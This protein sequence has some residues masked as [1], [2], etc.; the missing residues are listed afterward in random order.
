MT[1]DQAARGSRVAPEIPRTNG[2]IPPGRSRSRDPLIIF[3]IYMVLLI[4]SPSIYIVQPL[5]AAGTPAAIFGFVI[6]LLWVIG[7]LTGKRGWI[8]M[9]PLHWF[10]GVFILSVLLAFCA[11]ML[12]PISAIETSASLRGL[13]ATASAVGV[14][15]FA[16][17]SL[18]TR[19]LL[20]AF[21]RFLVLIGTALALMGVIQFFTGFNFIEVL[22][23]PG[24]IANSEVAGLYQ[25]AGYPRV[26]ATAI[27][28]I[29]FSAVIGMALP[30]AAHFALAATRRQWWR[31]GQL[32]IMLFALPL[33][34]ARSGAIAL[35]VGILF[36][37]WVGSRRQ[38]ALILVLSA[39]AAVVFRF[40]TPGLLGTIRSLF[41]GAGQDI[42][43]SGRLDD[44]QAVGAFLAQSPWVGR[45][46]NTFI[47]TVYRTLDNQ[48]LGTAVES[49][50]IG[51]AAL[52]LLFLGAI[53]T[54]LIVARRASGRVDRAQALS[55]ATALG[56]A[57]VLSLIFDFFGFS[58]AFGMLSLMFGASGALW[59]V[60][61]QPETG[62]RPAASTAR[63]PPRW[64][65]L[66]LLVIVVIGLI[67][68]S[69]VA[70][71]SA[72]S[73]YE[74]QGSLVLVVQKGPE[75]NTFDKATPITGVSDLMAYLID[76]RQTRDELTAAGVTD[77]SVAIGSGSLGPNTDVH[78]EGNIIRIAARAGDPQVALRDAERVR[79]K[80][81]DD[82]SAL[83]SNRGIPSSVLIVADHSFA[84][85]QVYE[86]SINRPFAIAGATVFG[87]L[88]V[89]LLVLGLR[90]RRARVIRRSARTMPQ[91]DR[92]AA[93]MT[94]A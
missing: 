17:D 12:R 23:I 58:M 9:T 86:R 74:A 82:L 34:I 48:F 39:I 6:F 50:L 3:Q 89:L 51:V 15:L 63:V 44:F 56:T 36:L 47:P 22:H 54:S 14:M 81:V 26:S 57:L 62:A 11:G 2:G 28:S 65:E 42:S 31:W 25:R 84:D 75:N 29:E 76:N 43:I 18:R 71:R 49:G 83:Q 66:I 19:E 77:Y 68:A 32:G 10:V 45:G 41:T 38:R 91:A 27:H 35:L 67:A 8:G 93:S 69:F 16:A 88:A 92:P 33:T 13:I 87:I 1:V 30:I 61:R 59:R 73:D 53:I 79:S 7:R 94:D 24:L 52:A 37:L 60:N 90:I 20:E 72:R 40:L 5:G 64:P 55:I 70:I 21:L 46:F 85:E 4:F 78:G 80:L